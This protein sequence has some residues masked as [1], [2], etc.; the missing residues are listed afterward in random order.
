MYVEIRLVYLEARVS[1]Q[2]E[3]LEPYLPR[4][5]CVSY[6]FH[7]HHTIELLCNVP[8]NVSLHR[9]ARGKFQM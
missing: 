1:S 2:Y 8:H 6:D 3:K 9:N 4:G 7:S 5:P